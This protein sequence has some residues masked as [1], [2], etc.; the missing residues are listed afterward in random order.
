MLY[1]CINIRALSEP[2]VLK[3]GLGCAERVEKKEEKLKNENSH[4][5]GLVWKHDEEP[6]VLI[7]KKSLLE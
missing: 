2:V 6:S 7:Q 1:G 5:T 3:F 4:Q